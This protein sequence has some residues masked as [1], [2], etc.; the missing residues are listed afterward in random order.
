MLVMTGPDPI[1]PPDGPGRRLDAEAPGLSE[2]AVGKGFGDPELRSLATGLVLTVTLVA[3]ESLAVATVMPQVKDDLGGLGLYGWVFS[4]FFLGSLVGITVSGQM[5]DRRGMAGPFALGIVLFAV[6][7][8][9]GGSAVSM[10]MLVAGRVLQGF[11]AG[12]IPSVAYTAIGRGIPARLR[13]RLFAI[14]SS[15]WVLPGLVG[16]VVAAWV[17]HAWSWR[18]VF[19]GLLPIVALAAAM[20]LPVLRGLDSRVATSRAPLE[21]GRLLRVLALVGG[22][23]LVLAGLEVPVPAIAVV[24]VVAGLPVAIWSFEVLQPPGT[25]RLAPGVPATVAVRGLLTCAFFMGDAYVPLAVTDGLGGET[26][27]A[28]VVLSVSAVLW[29]VAS[30]IQAQFIERLGPRRMVGLG[31]VALGV[32]AAVMFATMVGLPLWA[33]VAAWAVAALGMG[34]AYS[35]L[36]VTVLASATRGREGEASAALQ[37]SDTLGVA[38]GTGLGGAV[39]AVGAARGWAVNSTT[40]IVFVLSLVMAMVVVAASRRLPVSLPGDGS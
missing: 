15:A 31:G 12:A 38:V 2:V 27:V 13:P 21:V 28:G 30:W 8:V 29:S 5:A 35:P 40:S 3:F 16:P 20:S 14:L 26:W 10:P 33:A 11:G 18:W 7:L 17:E 24:L 22:V 23:G 4:G 37:L 25:A 32:G 9:V 36:S 1:D 39:V 19:L 34:F 6:G